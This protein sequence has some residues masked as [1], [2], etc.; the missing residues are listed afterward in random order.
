M[1]RVLVDSY[2]SFVHSLVQEVGTHAEVVVRRND[3]IDIDGIRELDPDGI[4][5][6]PGPDTPEA[7]A[8][9][10]DDRG[11]R[12]GDAAFETCRGYG[13]TVFAWDRHRRRWSDD[14]AAVG[15]IRRARRGGVLLRPVTRRGAA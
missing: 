7:A 4:V 3:E 6:S 14:V 15:P 8:V 1:T 12:Y 10:V 11:F 9:S 2:D 5:V 13:G